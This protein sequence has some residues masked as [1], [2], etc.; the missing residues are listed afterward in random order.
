MK[1]QRLLQ[2]MGE[3]DEQ[4][5]AEAAQPVRQ[6]RRTA[7]LRWGAAAA[8]L[9]VAVFAGARLLWPGQ[10]G[11]GGE[12]PLLTLTEGGAGGM[13]YEGYMAYDVSELVS[14][15]PW[16][17]GTQLSTLPV[18]QNPL[19]Y[20]ENSTP[21]GLDFPAM[22]AL[23]RQ[24]ADGLGLDSSTLVVTDNSPS[25]EYK[26][27]VREKVAAV[28]EELPE[29][30]FDP[31]A[32]MAEAEGIKLEVDSTFTAE[33]RF[34]P[35][36]ALPAEYNFTHFAS[37]DD[38]QKVAQYLQN[39]YPGLLGQMK[40]PRLN[41]TGGDYNI[42]GEQGYYIE[43][44]DGA[45]SQT[46]QIVNFNFRRVVFHCD[47]EGKL[48]LARV[49]WPQLS[50]KVGD[51]PIISAEEA[52]ELLLEGHYTTSVPYELPGEQYIAKVELIYRTS[53][54][55]AY[56]L[57]YYRFYVELPEEQREHGLKD[58]GAYY[59]PAVESRYIANMPLWGGQF[60]GGGAPAVPPGTP[61]W[62][63]K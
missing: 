8:C 58:Y 17:E 59:V 11:A 22:E 4:L 13:G 10:P 51:Y 56:H 31:T 14:A 34:E 27:A 28:G 12:L 16:Q 45:G 46:E 48:F 60:N 63:Q 3:I 35:A 6:N 40:E 50:Q 2:A 41:I 1:S 44:F 21:S 15:N 52:R 18:Y 36:I 38:V 47:D 61:V 25:E 29:G 55:E 49:F 54:Y 33:I 5:V 26:A 20:D 24:V 23:L 42:Y 30:Y 19:F 39:Q 9:A 7:W 62:D 32:V 57:P 53:S 43:F 37:Y